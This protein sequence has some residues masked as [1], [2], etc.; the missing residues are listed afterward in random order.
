M[1]KNCTKWKTG[2]DFNEEVNLSSSGAGFVFSVD[3]G[4][5]WASAAVLK[6]NKGKGIIKGK[7]ISF[8][9]TSLTVSGGNSIP[10]KL[11]VSLK[12]SKKAMSKIEGRASAAIK[13]IDPELAEKLFGKKMKNSKITKGAGSVESVLE[14]I[15]SGQLEVTSKE[16]IENPDGTVQVILKVKSI[17]KGN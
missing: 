11:T 5:S 15:E 3:G 16:I 9:K 13:K 4:Q 17:G 2:L 8:G 7:G 14:A 12:R 1:L 6:L 10:G